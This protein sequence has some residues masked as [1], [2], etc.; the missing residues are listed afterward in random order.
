M[1]DLLLKSALI[2]STLTKVEIVV[3]MLWENRLSYK[4]PSDFQ[5]DRKIGDLL[6]NR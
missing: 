6:G 5:L 3:E 4:K 2:A 1:Y